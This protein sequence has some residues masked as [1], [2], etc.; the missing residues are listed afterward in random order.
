MKMNKLL[1]ISLLVAGMMTVSSCS[2]ILDTP[3]TTSPSE[4]I[5]WQ[6]KSDFD[7]ALAGCYNIMQ[8]KT[9]SYGMV[10]YDCLTDNG[11]G[12]SGSSYVYKTDLIQADN[13]D[14]AMEGFVPD[15]YKEAYAAIARLNIFLYQLENYEGGDMSSIRN[16]YEGEAMFLR[17]YCYYLLYLC[18]GEV[19]YP[20]VPLDIT[21]Q[22]MPKET[23]DN[24]YKNLISDLQTAIDK[25]DDKTFKGSG[26]HATKGA[27]KALKARVLM[28]HAFGEDGKVTNREEVQEA[29]NLL[30]EIDGYSLTERYADNFTYDTQEASNEIVF[31]IKFLAPN[32]YNDFDHKYGNYAGVRPVADLT[33]CYE[34]GDNRLNQIV[35]F[36]DQYQW[37]GGEVVSLN[38]SS[39]KKAM[40]K[41]LTPLMKDG[42]SWEASNR[43][44]QDWGILR[45]GELLLL[46]AE[47][48]NE[49][50]IAGAAEMVNQ[51][52]N[53][54]GLGDLAANLT[55]DQMR[56]KIRQERRVE[57][58]FELIRYYDMKRWKMMDKL[59]GLELD[60]L[61][62]GHITAW[63]K[64]HEYFPLPQVQIDFSNGVLIQNP[65][66]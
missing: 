2:D 37:P 18:Y 19:P 15:L 63:S 64:A 52:R 28:F 30:N 35:A 43:S 39:L 7:S 45:W 65:N 34:D 51:V 48:A 26:G 41:W 33:N 10:V 11:Y 3:P 66:Y 21:T 14:A 13:I 17:S 59:N 20:T 57:T 23:L 6:S 1:Y 9:L 42:D 8:A 62:A 40:V 49:L 5:F 60:P 46:K 22:N 29:Y 56:E 55:Q 32:N 54:A 61:L 36:D 53:R 25:M 24:V 27:A 31:S 50:G 47:A 4:S 44:D 38:K 58:P 12:S 16:Q